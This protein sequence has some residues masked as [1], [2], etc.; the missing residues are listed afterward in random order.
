MRAR[1]TAQLVIATVTAFGAGIAFMAWLLP[2][3]VA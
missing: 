1:E 3:V 2:G